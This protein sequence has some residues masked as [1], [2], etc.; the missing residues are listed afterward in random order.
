MRIYHISIK[1]KKNLGIAITE[2]P[3]ASIRAVK[4]GQRAHR[5]EQFY[6]M[7]RFSFIFF[8]K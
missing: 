4:Q 3:V 1:Q 2:S 6:Q 8:A 5:K 7:E